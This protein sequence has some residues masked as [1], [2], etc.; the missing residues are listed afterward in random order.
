MSLFPPTTI[1]QLRRLAEANL[2][3]ECYQKYLGLIEGNIRAM[4]LDCL[5]FWRYTESVIT[6]MV[7]KRKGVFKSSTIVL[8]IE[9]SRKEDLE[10]LVDVRQFKEISRM[11]FIR[12][13]EYLRD[14]KI[15]TNNCYKVIDTAS[16]VR[17][18]IHNDPMVSTLSERD[19][20]LFNHACQIASLLQMAENREW[21]PVVDVREPTRQQAENYATKIVEEFHMKLTGQGGL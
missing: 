21:Y 10:K 11:K 9:G 3:G 4:A 12:K 17:N 8:S 16:R 13:I 18:R 5:Y 20:E 1:N 19:L 7:M 14:E 15:L 2:C 6:Q